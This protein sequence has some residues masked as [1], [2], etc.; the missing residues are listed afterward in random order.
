MSRALSMLV[1]PEA[2]MAAVTAGVYVVCARHASGEGRDL[3]LM[4]QLS[5]LLPLLAVA[6]V[7]LTGLAPGAASWWWLGRAV[8]ASFVGTAIFSYRI[9]EGFGEGAKGQ[10]AAYMIGFLSAGAV[11][12][13]GVAVFGA[14][15]RMGESP[16]FAAWFRMRPVTAWCLTLLASIPIGVALVMTLA[17]VGG[18]ALGLATA[19]K[20]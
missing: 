12:A 17:T 15:I 4:E 9:V 6:A 3:R 2:V 18:L 14:L 11:S 1:G 16:G 7:F 10:D 20:R 19:F 5:M 13:V 8:A